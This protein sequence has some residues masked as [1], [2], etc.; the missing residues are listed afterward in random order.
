MLASYFSAAAVVVAFVFTSENCPFLPDQI[1]WQKWRF[2]FVCF[3]HCHAKTIAETYFLFLIFHI[4]GSGESVFFLPLLSY[5]LRRFIPVSRMCDNG[6]LSF[7]VYTYHLEVFQLKW[8]GASHSLFLSLSHLLYPSF[9]ISSKHTH[10]HSLSLSLR[11]FL[12]LFF[13]G[14]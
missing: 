4:F 13:G 1:G 7:N 3:S 11:F 14:T 2:F 9:T 5:N 8:Y 10:T 6:K 12:L